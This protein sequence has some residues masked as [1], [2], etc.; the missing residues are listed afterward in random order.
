MVNNVGSEGAAPAD[1]IAVFGA[2]GDLARTKL[3]P[4]LLNLE[5]RGRLGIPVVGV[6]RTEWDDDDFRRHVDAV[7]A[8]HT[9]DA[10]PAR[11]CLVSEASY[12]SG[13]YRSPELYDRLAQ[14]LRHARLP[15][16]YLAVPP[17]L[18]EDVVAGLSRAGVAERARLVIEKPFG[19]D[20]STARRL[21]EVL[22]DAFPDDALFRVDHFLGKAAVQNMLV[23]RMANPVFEPAWNRGSIERVRIDM[24]EEALIRD[25][26]SFYDTVGATRDVLQNHLLEIVAL[27]AMEPPESSS[28]AAWREEKLTLFRATHVTG[29][30]LRGQYRG[31]REEK[32]VDPESET[33]TFVAATLAIDN[34]RWR[35]VPFEISTGKGLDRTETVATVEFRDRLNAVFPSG[36]C[37]PDQRNS[38]RFRVK[39]DDRITLRVQTRGVDQEPTTCPVELTLSAE[40]TLGPV[41]DAY[42][43]LLDDALD[44]RPAR[45]AG[46]AD[47]EEAW[48][49]VEPLLVDPPPVIPYEPGSS[50]PV[51]APAAAGAATG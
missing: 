11:R 2:S 37:G 18:F 33:E 46:A 31:Y 21:N 45:F 14:R 8:D 26:G 51:V 49:V 48:R 36:A 6:G 40:E 30:P 10:D 1:T 22:H 24:A 50:G 32:G 20:Q 12:V 25:R 3:L 13:D 16:I 43:V 35:D 47:V 15:V 34:D 42:E 7:L 19:R 9:H 4:A 27:L 44:G 28:A 29:R 39:P 17:G 41:P 23:F 38:L 5:R